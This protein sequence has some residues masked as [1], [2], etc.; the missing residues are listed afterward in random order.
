MIQV[1]LNEVPLIR[2]AFLSCVGRSAWRLW[3]AVVISMV[4]VARLQSGS[5]DGSFVS[6]VA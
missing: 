6:P 4:M 3:C 1:G 2:V 5:N